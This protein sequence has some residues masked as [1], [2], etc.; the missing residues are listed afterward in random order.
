MNCARFVVLV[1][2]ACF[3][4]FRALSTF[5]FLSSLPALSCVRFLLVIYFAIFVA[6]W[7]FNPVRCSVALIKID[8]TSY[9]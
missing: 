9:I 2:S 5:C 4:E 7:S 1:C 8:N 3:V 6:L